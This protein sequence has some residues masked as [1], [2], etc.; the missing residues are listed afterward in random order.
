MPNIAGRSLDPTLNEVSYAEQLRNPRGISTEDA[1]KLLGATLRGERPDVK[2]LD[3]REDA[4]TEM[5]SLP[6]A[7]H[8]RF[9][10][11]PYSKVDLANKLGSRALRADAVEAITCG[12]LSVV[13]VASLAAQAV[14]RFWWIDSVGSLAIL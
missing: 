3:I 14:L 10:D 12:W 1:E 7:S 2:F 13:A 6:G 11:L 8:V 4:E 9:P 5:G